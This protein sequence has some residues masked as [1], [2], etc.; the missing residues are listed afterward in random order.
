M[1]ERCHFIS[2]NGSNGWVTQCEVLVAAF[3][4]KPQKRQWAL[5]LRNLPT[6]NSHLLWLN[7][8]K[9]EKKA[10]LTA[11]INNKWLSQFCFTLNK[12]QEIPIKIYWFFPRLLPPLNLNDGGAG[13][14]RVMSAGDFCTP[15]VTDRNIMKMEI[16]QEHN[17]QLLT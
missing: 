8:K 4:C 2:N 10:I 6:T 5:F 14:L 7:E 1:S 13:E 16:R 17:V 11:D 9:K 15:V 3:L 12:P